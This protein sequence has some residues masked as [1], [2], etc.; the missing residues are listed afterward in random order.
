MH[1][2]C[3]AMLR[4]NSPVSPEQPVIAGTQ[5]TMPV[6]HDQA[7]RVGAVLRP[8]RSFIVHVARTLTKKPRVGKLSS[9]APRVTAVEKERA[10]GN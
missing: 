2:R 5:R 10:K 4:I 6:G 9:G 7:A 3:E 8:G 1:G